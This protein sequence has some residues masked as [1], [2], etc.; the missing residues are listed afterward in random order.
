MIIAKYIL[1]IL[2]CVS[3]SSS[4]II[5]DEVFL[6]EKCIYQIEILSDIPEKGPYTYFSCHIDARVPGIDT[7]LN[8][9]ARIIRR[10]LT[11]FLPFR[12]N[13]FMFLQLWGLAYQGTEFILVIDH[14]YGLNIDDYRLQQDNIASFNFL[15]RTLDGLDLSNDDYVLAFI[16]F[17]LR[18]STTKFIIL[19]R[20]KSLEDIWYFPQYLLEKYSVIEDENYYFRSFFNLFNEESMVEYKESYIMYAKYYMHEYIAD[21]SHLKKV[22][23]LIFQPVV[24]FK[25]ATI[26]VETLIVNSIRGHLERWNIILN[27]NGE[28]LAVNRNLIEENLGFDKATYYMFEPNKVVK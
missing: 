18:L 5:D 25:D 24:I 28:I 9:R 21:V 4:Q 7:K 23:E 1:L 8:T 11:Q 26:E 13:N 27:K 19:Y 16:D 17:Y 20:V 2:C 14:R 10:D 6:K 15:V 12:D 3:I 22:K